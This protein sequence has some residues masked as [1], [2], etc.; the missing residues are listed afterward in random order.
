M[1]L[2]REEC[3]VAQPTAGEKGVRFVRRADRNT[4]STSGAS[5]VPHSHGGAFLKVRR[6]MFISVIHDFVIEAQGP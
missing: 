6:P 1:L 5:F 4:G 3:L 2:A